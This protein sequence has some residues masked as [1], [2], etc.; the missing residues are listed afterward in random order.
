VMV[1]HI[2]RL[3]RRRFA[4]LKRIAESEEWREYVPEA[5]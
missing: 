5:G 3:L 2:R 4:L 1:P